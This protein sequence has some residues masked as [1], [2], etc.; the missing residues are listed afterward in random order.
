MA[1]R[2]QPIK[3]VTLADVARAAGVAPMTVSRFLNQHPNI[4]EKTARKVSAAIE[5]LGYSPNVAARM[6]MGQ[7]SNAIGLI[8][9]NLGDPFFAEVAHN[10]QE[11]A[12]E[13]GLLV[14]VAASNSNQETEFAI[15]RQMRQHC[16]DGMLLIATPGKLKFEHGNG[17]PIVL[18]DRPV[19][20]SGCDVVLVENRRGSM[21]AVTHLL[22]HGYKRILCIS[23]D[24]EKIYTTQERIA[25]YE[26]AM[27]SHGLKFEAILQAETA[28]SIRIY[29]EQALAGA[30][31]PEAI[32]TTNNV[33]TS[34]VMEAIQ[35]LNLSI[36]DDMALIGFDDFELASL[37]RPSLTVVRQPAADLGRQA[38][39]L[40]FKR[41]CSDETLTSI[42]LL[43]PATLILRASCGCPDSRFL[44]SSVQK[45]RIRGIATTIPL[46]ALR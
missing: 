15:L 28:E 4:S 20:N 24:C 7:P 18:L 6:L 40:L 34:H 3:S 9:P 21:E 44:S 39:R 31:P 32:F 41:I 35:E 36:P 17:T 23:S 46:P 42:S 16:V 1:T 12:R 14:W 19:E 37:L 22:S 11:I 26:D 25:G 38:A 27:R 29:L 2:K 43:L 13:H 8:V 30:A 10:I 45:T 33:T 5:R